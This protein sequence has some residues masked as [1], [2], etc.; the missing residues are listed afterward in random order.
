MHG[1]WRWRG[2]TRE[3]GTPI[4]SVSHEQ[5]TPD[6]PATRNYTE[7][8]GRSPWWRRLDQAV[9]VAPDEHAWREQIGTRVPVDVGDGHRWLVGPRT[10]VQIRDRRIDRLAG[11]PRQRCPGALV[12]P[13]GAILS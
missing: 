9:A 7:R 6:A 1:R 11:E 5:A 8:P 3:A 10:V 12:D 13:D 4:E 2:R